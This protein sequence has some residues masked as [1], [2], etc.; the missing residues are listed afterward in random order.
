VVD[1]TDALT[2]IHTHEGFTILYRVDDLEHAYEG[3]WSDYERVTGLIETVSV[4]A[5]VRSACQAYE[6]LGQGEAVAIRLYP[7]VWPHIYAA[8]GYM[9]I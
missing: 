1:T 3:Y 8:Q 4:P 7:I 5:Q 2:V 9:D 6:L